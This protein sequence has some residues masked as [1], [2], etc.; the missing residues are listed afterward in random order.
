MREIIDAAIDTIGSNPYRRLH[1]YPYIASK[2][3]ALQ[4]SI[5][6]VGLWPSII[7]RPLQDRLWKYEM[8]FGH[9]RLEAARRSGLKTIPL[10]VEDLTD[11][12]M[13]QYMGRENLEDYNA[14]FLIQLEAWE[15]GI[16]SGLFSGR[17]EK[18]RQPIDIARLLGWTRFR[19]DSKTE[20]L[21]DTAE[22][23]HAAYA[24]IEGGYTPREEFVGLTV[25]GAR[26]STERALAR[27][28]QLDKAAKGSARPPQETEEAKQHYGRAVADVAR[29]VREGKIARRD[30]R[31]RVDIAAA[32]RAAQSQR[33]SPLF[34]VFANAVADNLRRTVQTDSDA[35]KLAEIERALSQI[36]MLEDWESL[37]RLDVELFNLGKRAEAWQKRLI[38]PQDKVVHFKALEARQRS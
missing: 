36:T 23:C 7:A 6:D 9:H 12:Q 8:A 38:P 20:L 32:G 3:D 17:P 4:H 2:L 22:A 27:M 35:D 26:L 1:S 25:E 19:G 30:I 33:P 24:L 14:V 28:A 34:A 31:G 11:L 5:R 15:A 16:K 10:I 29:E 13:L 21:N 37:R 18:R